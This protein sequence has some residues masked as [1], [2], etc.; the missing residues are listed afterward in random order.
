MR[1]R[2]QNLG[3]CQVEKLY[4]SKLTENGGLQGLIIKWQVRLK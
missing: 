2:W 3:V 4:L 1:S